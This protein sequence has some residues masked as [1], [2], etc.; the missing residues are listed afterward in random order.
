MNISKFK[1]EISLYIIALA[2]VTEVISFLIIGW[3]SRFLIGL[4]IGT[5]VAIINT[6][7]LSSAATK[8]LDSG[9]GI[10]VF[11]TSILRMFIF[12]GVFVLSLMMSTM[13]AIGTA[14]SFIFPQISMLLHGVVIPKIRRWRKHEEEAQYSTYELSK[15]L[16]NNP[17]FEIDHNGRMYKTHHRFRIVKREQGDS[18][19]GR[20]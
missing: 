11:L 4:A 20:N 8:A 3:N 10:Y 6:I 16:I 2:I 18:K 12:V 15:V 7:L 9:K 14:I 5:A 19:K 1:K 17:W 13:S